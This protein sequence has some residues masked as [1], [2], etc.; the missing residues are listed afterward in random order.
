MIAK[1]PTL[2]EESQEDSNIKGVKHNKTIA[3]VMEDTRH[4]GE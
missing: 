2:S 1:T 4:L 3:E